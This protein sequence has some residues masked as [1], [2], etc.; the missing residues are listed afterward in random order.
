[1]KRKTTGFQKGHKIWLGRKHSETAKKQMSIKR[2]GNTNGFRKGH[3]INLGRKHSEKAK[4]KMREIALKQKRNFEST[5]IELKIRDELIKRGLI[6]NIDFFR[7]NLVAD[8]ENVDFYLHFSKTVIQADGCYYNNCLIHHPEHHK[9][10]REKDKKQDVILKN[11]GYT[12]LRFWEHEI[13]SNLKKCIVE[14]FL[15]QLTKSQPYE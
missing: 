2:K 9:E 1:M 14:V 15:R 12:V 8:I 6:E 3:K 13:N 10:V 7:N 11:N 5:S 4:Q